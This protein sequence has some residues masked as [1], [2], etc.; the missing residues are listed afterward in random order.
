[1]KTGTKLQISRLISEHTRLRPVELAEILKIS[2]QALHRHL[3]TL[4]AQGVLELQ[5]S[6][7]MT[8]YALAG[9]PDFSAMLKWFTAKRGTGSPPSQVCETRDAFT[10]RLS[11][12]KAA[13]KQG[14]PNEDLPLLIAVTGEIGN[15]S[16]DHNLGQWRDVSGCWFQTQITGG[17]LWVCIADR[18]QGVFK[19][20]LR[21]D[22]TIENE[23]KALELAFEKRISGRAPERRGNGLKFVR[24]AIVSD[25]KNRGLACFS[26]TG[27][28]FLG[29]WER[30]RNKTLE[31]AAKK[32]ASGTLT[33]ISWGLS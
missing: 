13:T 7:P 25:A 8:H 20:L 6:P 21:V 2:P 1:M 17:R 5:G 16:F 33:F 18:G 31:S 10:A 28:Y 14:L 11:Q 32:A 24:N 9:V 26:G 30:D 3:K 27:R 12:L 4:V 29:N 23:Q 22:P 15:N 19:S